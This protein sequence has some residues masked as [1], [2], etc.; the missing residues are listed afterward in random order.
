MSAPNPTDVE[1]QINAESMQLEAAIQEEMRRQEELAAAAARQAFIQEEAQRRLKERQ[2]L[3]AEALRNAE[4]ERHRQ[5]NEAARAAQ[6]ERDMA[7]ATLAARIK[8]EADLAAAEAHR[9]A[10]IAHGERKAAAL[11]SW[12]LTGHTWPEGVGA[13]YAKQMGEAGWS[14]QTLEPEFWRWICEHGG[15]ASCPTCGKQPTVL[16]KAT[17][18]SEEHYTEGLWTTWNIS[19]GDHRTGDIQSI[20][21]CE[22][23]WDFKERRRY[24]L[25]SKVAGLA[26]S[27]PF[28]VILAVPTYCNGTLEATDRFGVR[29]A[30]SPTMVR[31]AVPAD[32]VPYNPED[33]DG[34][35][36]EEARRLAERVA[37]LE[38]LRVQVAALEGSLPQE[39]PSVEVPSVSAE[40]PAEAAAGIVVEAKQA[41][42][43]EHSDAD[44]RYP[45]YKQLCDLALANGGSKTVICSCGRRTVWTPEAAYPINCFS[46]GA[47]CGK[48][49]LI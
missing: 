13:A 41:S 2:R 20:Y 25:A 32:Y 17:R 30:Q 4:A 5:R 1:D 40:K 8:A 29:H 19:T 31:K 22:H 45:S 34:S 36:A 18:G 10:V 47:A 46:Q 23:L 42:A 27:R 16:R 26:A 7:A 9:Q 33:P 15:F 43:Q 12:L 6:A 24:I 14:K 37:Q 48:A 44:P 3:Q 35:R 28:T 38:R 39:I 11:A 21:C 49:R